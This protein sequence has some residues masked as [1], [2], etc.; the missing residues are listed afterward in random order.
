MDLQ[1]FMKVCSYTLKSHQC[2]RSSHYFYEG[3]TH[4]ELSYLSINSVRTN[5]LTL[6]PFVWLPYAPES[7]EKLSQRAAWPLFINKC[8]SRDFLGF[9]VRFGVILKVYPPQRCKKP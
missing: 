5:G 3:L 8:L 4:K 2:W 9:S 7:V 1:T 6:C